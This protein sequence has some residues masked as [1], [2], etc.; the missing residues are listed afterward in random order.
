MGVVRANARV[1]D[2]QSNEAM[3]SQVEEMYPGSRSV[4]MLRGIVKNL[5]LKCSVKCSLLLCS[6]HLSHH[7]CIRMQA[8]ADMRTWIRCHAP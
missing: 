5:Q 8:L 4:G 7:V 2:I 6:S 3:V 1:A